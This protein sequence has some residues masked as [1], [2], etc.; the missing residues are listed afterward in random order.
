MARR[1][2]TYVHMLCQWNAVIT[3]QCKVWWGSVKLLCEQ[4]THTQVDWMVK[5]DM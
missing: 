1:L 3:N 4:V 2:Y 5:E